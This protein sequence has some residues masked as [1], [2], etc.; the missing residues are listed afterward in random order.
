MSAQNYVDLPASLL[1]R[2]HTEVT[3]FRLSVT[4]EQNILIGMFKS[5]LQLHMLCVDVAVMITHLA[6]DFAGSRT[7]SRCSPPP[8][9]ADLRASETCPPELLETRMLDASVSEADT[10]AFDDD[11]SRYIMVKQRRVF[12]A[13]SELM[14]TL[15]DRSGL[16]AQ[17]ARPEQDRERSLCP[18]AASSSCRRRREAVRSRNHQRRSQRRVWV[19]IGAGDV[20]LTR[21]Q[22]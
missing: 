17:E 13:S 7:G 10:D 19:A 14:S 21:L 8:G 6:K 16:G 5:W 4:E 15:G 22:T 2:S 9:G 1:S 18:N 3:T 11:V 20:N 12:A